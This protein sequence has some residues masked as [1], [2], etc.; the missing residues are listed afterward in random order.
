MYMNQEQIKNTVIDGDDV[1]DYYWYCENFQGF[2]FFILQINNYLIFE[3][4]YI[5]YRIV[6]SYKNSLLSF[7]NNIWAII[8]DKIYI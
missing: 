4:C 8:D 2:I 7:G 6:P 1:D 3:E 5:H